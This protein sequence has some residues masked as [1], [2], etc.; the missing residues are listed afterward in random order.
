MENT[1][2]TFKRGDLVYPNDGTVGD[3]K[4]QI[5]EVLAIN[6]LSPDTFVGV[7][8]DS[9]DIVTDWLIDHFKPVPDDYYDEQDFWIRNQRKKW[10]DM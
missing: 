6:A 2:T 5:V 8:L 1:Q 4:Y 9:G 10:R 7:S 3:I